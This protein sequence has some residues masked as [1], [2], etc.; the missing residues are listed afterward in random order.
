MLHAPSHVLP[1]TAHQAP[2]AGAS[3]P[4][5]RIIP[6]S[7]RASLYLNLRNVLSNHEYRRTGCM[8]TSSGAINSQLSSHPAAVLTQISS[9]V[10][11]PL[12]AGPSSILFLPFVY[13]GC[14]TY[15]R[16]T[17]LDLMI[18]SSPRRRVLTGR[19]YTSLALN[20]RKL[21]PSTSACWT[22][23][24]IRY[25][26]LRLSALPVWRTT[27][28]AN[29]EVDQAR[30]LRCLLARILPT[31]RPKLSTNSIPP[32][33]AA[34][35]EWLVCTAIIH[36]A[37]SIWLRIEAPAQT[38]P[39]DYQTLGPFLE[40]YCREE[41]GQS[42]ASGSPFTAYLRLSAAVSLARYLLV[43]YFFTRAED[44]LEL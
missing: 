5:H 33:V 37:R 35:F 38:L 6:D 34:L 9:A 10:G 12:T 39:E 14:R 8:H 42:D 22:R 20:L 3:N 28:P 18:R 17:Y 40:S 7:R 11:S 4:T 16:Q 15:R 13:R 31:R 29:I 21:C 36:S 24:L 44:L 32:L 43:Q 26:P 1:D 23:R 2:F 30:L 25:I 27:G 19:H 41:S